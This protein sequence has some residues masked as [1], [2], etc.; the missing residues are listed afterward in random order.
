MFL[1][2]GNRYRLWLQKRP[3][4]SKKGTDDPGGVLDGPGYLYRPRQILLEV[5]ETPE[6]QLTVA[7]LRKQRAEADAKLNRS[8][9]L[10]KTAGAGIPASS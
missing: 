2:D 5:G 9:R 7:E 3:P 4:L 10:A 8:F 1:E 6:Y